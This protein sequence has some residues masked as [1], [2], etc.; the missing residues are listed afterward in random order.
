MSKGRNCSR[1]MPALSTSA[2]STLPLQFTHSS[3]LAS[4]LALAA[5]GMLSISTQGFAQQV[6][7]R[8]TAPE[9]AQAAA[10][11]AVQ[12][13]IDEERAQQQQLAPEDPVVFNGG[14]S[15]E[16]R[17]SAPREGTKLEFFVASGAYL[18]DV[19]VRVEDQ[20]GNAIVD[21]VTE[22]PWLILDLP[23]GQYNV[24]ASLGDDSVQS[25]QIMVD[26]RA[27]H[28][29]YMFPSEN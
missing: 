8:A 1:S 5:I 18:S 10:Q 21:T 7:P 23:D 13:P 16:E 20:H 9:E 27:E 3:R 15:L 12:N 6:A 29:G 4:L 28:Y 17:A 24:Q 14:I 2:S 25:G 26:S 19:N 22:G 11:T